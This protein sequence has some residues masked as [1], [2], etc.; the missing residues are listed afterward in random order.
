MPI[1]A[2]SRHTL[3]NS[4][5]WTE[6]ID[7]TAFTKLT[8]LTDVAF[9]ICKNAAYFCVNYLIVLVA[10]LAYSLISNPFFIIILVSLTRGWIFLYSRRSSEEPLMIL[11]CT[12]LETQA[13]FGLGV[14]TLIMILV[15]SVM[16]LLLTAVMVRVGIICVH[17]AF[18]DP[19]DLLL[20]ET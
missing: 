3:S 16:L 13:M 14:A 2:L 6:L 7:H 17:R 10:V 12:I 18:R 5:P 19:D 15:T 20:E 11:G 8:L 1:V 4:R 9:R